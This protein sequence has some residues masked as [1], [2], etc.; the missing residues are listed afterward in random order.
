MT[1]R[2]LNQFQSPPSTP[3]PR[4]NPPLSETLHTVIT[5]TRNQPNQRENIS[6]VNSPYY[7]PPNPTAHSPP[8]S[9]RG[10]VANFQPLHISNNPQNQRSTYS[11]TEQV[12]IKSSANA[13]PIQNKY[14]LGVWIFDKSPRNSHSE[15]DIKP[16]IQRT[17]VTSNA[18][19]VDSKII[20]RKAYEATRAY[21]PI[22]SFVPIVQVAIE[23]R[24]N[25]Q[26]KSNQGSTQSIQYSRPSTPKTES[27]SGFASKRA[28]PSFPEN[29]QFVSVES[30]QSK[31]RLVE[32]VSGE[33]V[34]IEL[35][36]IGSY[37]GTFKNNAMHGYGRLFDSKNRL[38][39]EGEFADNHFEGLGVLNN[40]TEDQTIGAVSMEQGFALPLN[41]LRFE[42]LFHE[43]QKFGMSYL[44][45]ADGSCFFGEFESD[46][47]NGFGSFVNANGESI[48][49]TWSNNV[50]LNR[51]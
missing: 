17:T 26:V 42:G 32:Q 44:F 43:S 48:K 13:K 27:L 4:T 1:S 20:D 41:W 47:A 38:V 46:C 39:Y 19:I 35:D 37:E 3:Y 51:S 16:N 7:C 50:L 18:N 34:K 9:E 14:G 15:V 36:G 40:F 6:L 21:T 25:Q 31:I 23:E 2:P 10:I 29:S 8:K 28:V 33:M 22:K 5:T 49:G 11:E 45:F 12:E 24:P 30:V